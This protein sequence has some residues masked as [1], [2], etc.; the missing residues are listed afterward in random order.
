MVKGQKIYSSLPKKNSVPEIFDLR[1]SVRISG[2]MAIAAVTGFC[3]W[4]WA[5]D[6]PLNL[7]D[8]DSLLKN[9]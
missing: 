3:L 7:A 5:L 6:C 2:T 4:D 9:T 1:I 8:R